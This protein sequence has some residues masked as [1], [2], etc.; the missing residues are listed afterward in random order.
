MKS[1]QGFRRRKEGVKMKRLL[2]KKGSVLFLVLVVM[3][4]LIIAASATY[5]VVNNQRSSVNIRYSSEQAY[6]TATSMSKTV[7][8][9]IDSFCNKIGK[10]GNVSGI[11]DNEDNIIT[12]M[13]ALEDGK[14]FA[15]DNIDFSNMAMGDAKVTITKLKT[16]V[17]E[18]NGTTDNIFEI[19]TEAVINDEKVTIKQTK[20]IT[21]SKYVK[22]ADPFTRFLTST[23]KSSEALDTYVK[24]GSIYGEAFFD[25]EY[26]S[27]SGRVNTSVYSTGTLVD[28]GILYDDCP[29]YDPTLE[30]VI[31]ENFI[32]D[33]G[34]SHDTKL[35]NC[36]V[37]GNMI[38]S[39]QWQ[40]KNT[41]VMGDLTIKG[42]GAKG[43]GKVFVKGDAYVTPQGGDTFPLD[44][45]IKGNLYVEAPGIYYDM[46]S[47]GS[48]FHVG[49][50]IYI[51][52]STSSDWTEHTG[53]KGTYDESKQM[54]NSVAQN[55]GTT[56]EIKSWDDVQA[57]I[58]NK[59]S[60]EEYI[61]WD[62]EKY[63]DN[64]LNKANNLPTI[65]PGS[66]GN[67]EVTIT[68]S[69]ILEPSTAW[70]GDYGT[71]WHDII[72]DT[73]AANSTVYIK[74][75]PLDGQNTFSFIAKSGEAW[76]SEALNVIIKGPYAVVLIL[77]NG[78]NFA[79]SN[80]W[81]IGHEGIAVGAANGFK[82]TD[83]KNFEEL[84]GGTGGSIYSDYFKG[85]YNSTIAKNVKSMIKLTP[86]GNEIFDPNKVKISDTHNNLYLVTTG[87]NCKLTFD[88]EA[89][90]CGY[91][92][93]PYAVLTS[94][95]SSQKIAFI[96]GI[97]LSSYTY[98]DDQAN[99]IF[100][101]PY[102][103][104]GKYKPD[105]TADADYNK[106]DIVKILMGQ[107]GAKVP[108]SEDGDITILSGWE[109]IGY[110]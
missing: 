18:E 64:T 31:A 5:Y 25:N 77:P 24:T 58:D 19:A 89:T 88:G 32:M 38:L 98:I 12:K 62:A 13:L 48:E 17:D 87:D 99:L 104:K 10:N 86:E 43:V 78:V 109:N 51:R 76:Q 59:A 103:Y 55:D 61:E 68:G 60:K 21:T 54:L 15:T 107:S 4:L 74:L 23:G 94:N 75:K 29:A 30:I 84:K 16:V 100:T 85:G 50:K 110:K 26:S 14:S 40:V 35:S 3:S 91:V 8:D 63:F 36:F 22:V 7:S 90:F 102:D 45:Y 44:L 53:T 1:P 49:G 33:S 46:N 81:F 69:C 42:N 82:G 79:T 2:N 20:Q 47:H 39:R 105:G 95:G 28:N 73:N 27:L 106:A 37:G 67:K 108:G 93:A 96:G 11:K 9:Y 57:Y 71:S 56:V 52:Y 34:I 65:R 66:D 6:Q 101:T 80:N 92:Y 83:Y 41:Y 70:V 97:V 72:I